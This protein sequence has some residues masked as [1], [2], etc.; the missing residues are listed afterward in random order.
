MKVHEEQVG[1]VTVLTP[2]GDMDATVLPAF[3]AQ[4]A[5]LIAAGRINLLWDLSAVLFLPSTAVGFLLQSVQRARAAGGRCALAGGSE[6]VLGTL[7]TMA[8]LDIF[9]TYETRAEA[10]ADFAR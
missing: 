4:V 10:L 5:R 9:P 2:V 6:R 1:G 7:K 3:E 8:V